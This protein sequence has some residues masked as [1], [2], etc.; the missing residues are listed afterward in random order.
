MARVYMN[1]A[2]T[3]VSSDELT[4][5]SGDVLQGKIYQ[6]FDTN[7]EGGTGTM[8]NIEHTATGPL[9]DSV[10]R[11]PN[12]DTQMLYARIP[13]GY[14][15]ESDVAST[16]YIRIPNAR[17]GS[18]PASAVKAGQYFT[19]SE[20]GWNIQGTLPQL[21]AN[22]FSKAW[23]S[24]AAGVAANLNVKSA[25]EGWIPNNTLIYNPATGN[26]T[27]TPSAGT[28]NEIIKVV[29]QLIHQVTVNRTNPYNAGR[30]AK[31]VAYIGATNANNSTS[32]KVA[33]G[34]GDLIVFGWHR[35]AGSVSVS[36][37]NADEILK[38]GLSEQ[39]VRVWKVRS[40]ATVTVSMSVSGASAH[41]EASVTAIRIY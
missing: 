4:A 1:P 17:V 27:V 26:V 38:Q 8:P 32:P 40:A 15:R 3:G 20:V 16:G 7:D 25:K 19:S 10:G 12:S 39:Q 35:V 5:M 24:T 33:C 13:Y 30:A 29:P 14:Y 23:S 22:N 6:G 28:G 11:D 36:V 9:V 37:T 18:A 41:Y 34:A 21:N 31:S 2:G